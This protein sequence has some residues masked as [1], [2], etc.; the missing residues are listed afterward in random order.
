MLL[1]IIYFLSILVNITCCSYTYNFSGLY[2]SRVLKLIDQPLILLAPVYSNQTFCLSNSQGFLDNIM[3]KKADD[4]KVGS[5]LFRI[6][7]R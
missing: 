6:K 4:N 5:I 2:I 3:D 1:T 7:N